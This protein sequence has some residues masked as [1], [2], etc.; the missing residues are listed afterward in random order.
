MTL[1]RSFQQKHCAF[2]GCFGSGDDDEQ[3]LCHLS[4]Q[5][6][7]VLPKVTGELPSEQTPEEH[8]WAAYNE[9][10]AVAVRNGAPQATYAI[11]R[12]ALRSYV[13]PFDPVTVREA[14]LRER[15]RGGPSFFVVPRLAD[16]PKMEEFL[17]ERVPEVSYV[18]DHG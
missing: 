1:L 12:R 2:R 18:V 6:N 5:H 10:L 14:L 9:S 4:R 16:L 8:I 15:Y 3:L 17:R 11:D 7:D 13:A